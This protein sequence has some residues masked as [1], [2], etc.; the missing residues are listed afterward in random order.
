MEKLRL[1]ES[2]KTDLLKTVRY[3]IEKKLRGK[4]TIEKP[5]LDDEVFSQNYGLFV[6]L[7]TD[8]NLRGCI[9]YLEGYKP[10][11][12]AVQEMAIQAAFHD[13]RFHPLKED[14]YD[15]IDIEI[16]ILYPL[17]EVTDFSTI[18]VGRD[19]LVM[20]RGFHKGLLLPQVA[21]E[22][23]W[24]R[25]RFMNETCRKAGMESFCWENGAKVLK[26]EAEVF[27]EQA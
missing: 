5:S 22:Y 17:E 15:K 6:T 11:R 12:D 21:T 19:G 24:N 7:T 4:S 13:P 8:G 1:T 2:Q 20:E 9:G 26:F 3:T 18:K 27:N 23:G 10:I 16:S 25:E 14:E